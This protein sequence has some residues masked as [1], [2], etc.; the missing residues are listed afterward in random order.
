MSSKEFWKQVGLGRKQ[1]QK[2]ARP[3]RTSINVV[4]NESSINRG[5]RSFHF[6]LHK[7]C[8]GDWVATA[9]V[10]LGLPGKVALSTLCWDEDRRKF[11]CRYLGQYG[12]MYYKELD[13]YA[14]NHLLDCKPALIVAV[15]CDGT[16]LR[17]RDLY[18]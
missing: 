3:K 2:K 12:R 16:V 6:P 7:P 14:S 10:V 9:S 5:I 1:K 13:V 15:D 11:K 4:M 17:S 18:G 8:N